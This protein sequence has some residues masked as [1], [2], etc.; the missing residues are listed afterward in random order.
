MAAS[1]RSAYAYPN[2]N[3]V[4]PVPVSQTYPSPAPSV[5]SSRYI[6]KILIYFQTIYISLKNAHYKESIRNT[7]IVYQLIRFYSFS[8]SLSVLF[9]FY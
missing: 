6:L 3:P 8:F 2:P 5:V 7:A 9:K 4:P 1:S